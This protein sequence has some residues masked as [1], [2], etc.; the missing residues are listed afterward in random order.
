MT[1]VT[2]VKVVI[3]VTV[4]S[5][6]KN[7]KTSPQKKPLKSYITYLLTYL[8]TYVTVVTVVTVTVLTIVTVVTVVIVVSSEKNRANFKKKSRNLS[9]LLYIF[10]KTFSVLLEIPTWHIC[11]PRNVSFLV[12]FSFGKLA[13]SPLSPTCLNTNALNCTLLNN[14]Y[15][16]NNNLYIYF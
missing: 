7:N 5:S 10:L 6:E 11:D 15:K 16:S 12:M 8:P 13:R 14:H 3:V 4:V 1:V 2:V 9:F